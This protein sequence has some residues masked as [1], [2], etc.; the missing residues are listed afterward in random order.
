M[1]KVLLTL[2]FLTFRICRSQ[3][4]GYEMGFISDNDSYTSLINDKY[5]TNGLSVYFSYLNRNFNSKINKKT[6]TFRLNQSVYTPKIRN[7][8]LASRVDR[9]PAGS[10]FVEIKKNYFYQSESVFKLGFQLGVV[11]PKALAQE[12][13]K[14]LH[15]ILRI[16]Q[17]QGW[18]FQIQ[19][20]V[21]V[22]TNVMF[23]KKLKVFNNL[24]KTDFH[25][26]SETNFGTVLVG[27]TAGI[28]ARIGLKNLLLIFDS[29]YYGAGLNKDKMLAKSQSESYFFVNSGINYQVFDA[30]Y[31]GSL[32][33]DSSPITFDLIPFRWVAS[34]GYKYRKNSLNLSYSVIYQGKEARSKD[35]TG[36][37]YGSIGVGFIF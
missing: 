8:V 35:L 31:Q 18:Q 5:Y 15:D 32:F 12:T 2:L 27:T 34:A 25:L 4:S 20:A 28:S 11:G 3:D 7:L 17:V 21:A 33:D 26:H 19:N 36:F 16:D 29:N 6:T 23:S 10:V 14:I 13:Q 1:R 30:T 24:Q 37:Y 9:P 22:Q